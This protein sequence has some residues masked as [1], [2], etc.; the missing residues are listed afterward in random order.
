MLRQRAPQ[1]ETRAAGVRDA[2]D[3]WHILD[4]AAIYQRAA[5]EIAPQPPVEPQ[6]FRMGFRR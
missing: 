4:L 2:A 1:L 3:R 5:D 6:I